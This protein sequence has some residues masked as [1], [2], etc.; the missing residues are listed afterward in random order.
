METVQLRVDSN[1]MV[2]AVDCSVEAVHNIELNGVRST[3]E[4][5]LAAAAEPFD[6]NGPQDCASSMAEV[7]ADDGVD[8]GRLLCVNE[9]DPVDDVKPNEQTGQ[10]KRDLS[11]VNRHFFQPVQL[12]S[13]A[14]ADYSAELSRGEA[15][16]SIRK[17]AG[18]CP[19]FMVEDV[20][21]DYVIKQ[22]MVEPT[23]LWQE[24]IGE[25]THKLKSWLRKCREWL[26][27]PCG[28][29]EQHR[30]MAN[31]DVEACEWKP[32]SVTRLTTLPVEGGDDL[33]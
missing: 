20:A 3:G 7:A 21:E 5:E 11:L 16:I 2:R 26:I 28:L 9:L 1:A 27:D 15:E 23:T 22:S 30:E 31:H 19:V 14:G 32:L 24:A 29:V 6:S 10:L 33:V 17:R 25:V 12:I 4:A 18:V 13:D 8:V